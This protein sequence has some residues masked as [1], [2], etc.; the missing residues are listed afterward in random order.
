MKERMIVHSKA[1]LDSVQRGLKCLSP[2]ATGG[3]CPSSVHS[4]CSEKM[5]SVQH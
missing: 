4:Q 1:I 5:Q 3:S 2:E